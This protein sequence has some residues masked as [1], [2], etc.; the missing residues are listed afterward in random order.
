[1]EKSNHPTSAVPQTTA[2]DEAA[3]T[4]PPYSGPSLSGPAAPEGQRDE[5]AMEPFKGIPRYPGLPKLDYKLYSPPLF[6]LSSDSITLSSKAEYLSSNAAALASLIRAQSTVPPKPQIQVRGS[7][8]RRVDFDIKLNLMSLLVPDDERM[9]MDYIRCVGEGEVAHR[10]GVRPDVLPEVGEGGLEEWCRRFVQD[11][12]TVKTFAL[13]R[14]VANL[15]VGWLEGHLR[16]LIASLKYRGAVDVT[17]LVTHSRVLVQNPDRVN[18]FFTNVT[19]LFSGKNKYEV[20]KAVWPFATTKN[21]EPGRRCIVQSEEVWWK[22]WKDPIR[23]A[24]SQKR[25]GWVTVEDKLEAVM[26]GKGNQ[27]EAV[28]WGPDQYGTS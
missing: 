20:V 27:T 12:A 5:L 10:G 25:Q 6:K 7:R 23:Y 14:V 16:S 8:G 3:T 19:S 21:G 9:R 15:D 28:D 11:T 18:Q 24:I 26:E 17:F 22:E 2:E 13:D 1:M 4:P